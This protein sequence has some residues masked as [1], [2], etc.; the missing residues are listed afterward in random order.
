[1]TELRA[2]VL[3]PFVPARDY[4]LSKKFYVA[5]G[6]QVGFTSEHLTEYKL[7]ACRFYLQNFYDK[8]LASNLVLQLFVADLDAW[9][10]HVQALPDTVPGTRIMPPE[11]RPWGQRMFQV[12][13]PSGVLWYITYTGGDQFS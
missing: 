11:D 5:L 2:S 3:M 12:F 7:G 4:E 8:G 1:M 13:D 6:F 10:E 9:W